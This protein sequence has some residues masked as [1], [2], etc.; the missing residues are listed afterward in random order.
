MKNNNDCG[1]GITP[2]ASFPISS[3]TTTC[4]TVVA[5]PLNT[6]A[7]AVPTSCGVPLPPLPSVISHPTVTIE[8][9]LSL[10]EVKCDKA[11]CAV[12]QFE[13]DLLYALLTI[14]KPDETHP[15]HPLNPNNPSNV[16]EILGISASYP[17][18]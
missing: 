10:I 17:W 12:L 14:P 13:I 7:P 3:S 18:T 11:T 2:I 6:C 4:K 16:L 1:C 8:N 9:L 15:D 5:K